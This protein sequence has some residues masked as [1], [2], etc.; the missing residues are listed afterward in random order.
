MIRPQA[1]VR[2]PSIQSRFQERNLNEE[3]Q[4]GGKDDSSGGE[5]SGSSIS[6]QKIMIV[7]DSNVEFKNAVQW[8]LTH[9]IQNQDMLIFLPVAKPSKQGS[10]LLCVFNIYYGSS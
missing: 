3:K 9:T 5:K 6:C 1:R 2:Q 7:A 4:R 8:A 10:F